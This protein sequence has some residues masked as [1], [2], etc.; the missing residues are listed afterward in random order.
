M[1]AESAS[2][3][4]EVARVKDLLKA[5]RQELL[6][7][8]QVKLQLTMVEATNKVTGLLLMRLIN[9]DSVVG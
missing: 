2:H 5:L 7:A 3:S 1:E 6:E 4:A 8:E 9:T